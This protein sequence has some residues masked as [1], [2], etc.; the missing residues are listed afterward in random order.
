MA[1]PLF[2]TSVGLI[3]PLHLETMHTKPDVCLVST[4]RKMWGPGCRKYRCW[5][6]SPATVQ[7][8]SKWS[9]LTP[10][11]DSSI[12][13]CLSRGKNRGGEHHF[14]AV[15]DGGNRLPESCLEN[16]RRRGLFFHAPH[17]LERL[18]SALLANAII[19]K[20]NDVWVSASRLLD[21]EERRITQETD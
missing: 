1:G 6:K 7:T 21:A 3:W 18:T 5:S 4:N 16:F 12:W 2:S 15:T 10:L 20:H 11:V 13:W 19:E 14:N 9:H 17:L 8:A